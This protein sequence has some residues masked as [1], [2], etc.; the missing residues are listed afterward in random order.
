M[1][2]LLSFLT[3]ARKRPAYAWLVALAFFL[4]TPFAPAPWAVNLAAQTAPTTT[5]LSAA[6]TSTSAPTMTVSSASGFN[7]TSSTQ[8]YY[9]LIDGRELVGI[10]AITGTTISILRGQN[11]TLAMTHASGAPVVTGPATAFVQAIN[12]RIKPG[13]ALGGS[14][15]STNEPYLPL[16]DPQNAFRYNCINST[17]M[18]D[19]GYAFLGP[20]ACQSSV[21]GNGS[22]TNGYTA[23]GTAPSIPVVQASTSSTGTNTHYYMCNLNQLTAGLSVGVA[24]TVALIDVVAYYG[25]Q[26]TALGTQVAT[27]ASGTMNSKTVFTKIALPAAAASETA[28]G[29]AEAARADSGTLVITPVVGSFNVGTTTAGEFF[30]AKFAPASAIAMNTDSQMMLFTLS[31]LNTATSA[32]VTNSPGILVHYAYL[33]D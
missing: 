8:Q 18:V 4:A 30:S 33:P 22:G 24:R 28:T 17:W 23:L 15:T 25:V 19:N 12:G 20:A 9:A 11:G 2:K 29:L 1:T 6:I 21:S 5:T 13:A 14:C 32:T 31:L 10:R 3:L 26:T 16:Y 27:L 7:A